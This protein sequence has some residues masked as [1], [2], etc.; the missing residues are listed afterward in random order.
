MNF[1]DLT[2]NQVSNGV[3]LLHASRKMNHHEIE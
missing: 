2:D 3:D 1:V